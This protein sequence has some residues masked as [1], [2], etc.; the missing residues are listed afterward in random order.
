MTLPLPE[1]I[2]S[3]THSNFSNRCKASKD[4]HV[5]CV[6]LAYLEAGKELR[7]VLDEVFGGVPDSKPI[8]RFLAELEDSVEDYEMQQVCEKEF[9]EKR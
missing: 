5:A 8:E 2:A 6:K 3:R 9:E 7:R 4:E 1:E